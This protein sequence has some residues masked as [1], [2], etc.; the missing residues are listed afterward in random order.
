[1]LV[2]KDLP[3][4]QQI[5]QSCHA[6]IEATASFHPSPSTHPHLVVCGVADE[7][8]LLRALQSARQ[9]E[10]PCREF[11]EPDLDN[12]VTAFATAPIAG[13]LRRHFR[14]YRLLDPDRSTGALAGHG[15]S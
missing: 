14:K 4:A 3:T 11:V 2:R 6:V 7:S 5:V 10:I 8:A 12:Q 15:N 13:K 1:V 9:A